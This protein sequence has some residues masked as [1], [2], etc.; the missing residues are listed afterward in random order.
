MISASS[1]PR[2]RQGPKFLPLAHPH[3]N[4]NPG[5]RRDDEAVPDRSEASPLVLGKLRYILWII[6]WPNPEDET[7]VAPGISLAKS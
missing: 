1:S 4:L 7:C 6:A 5:L 3:R 2:R